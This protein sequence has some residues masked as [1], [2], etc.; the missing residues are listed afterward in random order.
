MK[1]MHRRIHI[2]IFL[3][4]VIVALAL[5][6]CRSQKYE[7]LLDTP[8]CWHDICPGVSTKGEAVAQLETLEFVGDVWYDDFY[9]ENRWNFPGAVG[10]GS[11]TYDEE[12]I[13]ESII[14]G[15]SWPKPKLDVNELLGPPPQAIA[16]IGCD[17]GDLATPLVIVL[18]YPDTYLTTFLEPRPYHGEPGE[19]QKIMVPSPPRVSTVSYHSSASYNDLLEEY[20]DRIDTID[21]LPADVKDGV[22]KLYLEK[23]C[24]WQ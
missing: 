2:R 7:A 14:V 20:V 21:T 12:Q 18:F 17:Y 3:A 13:V 5:S 24:S 19:T 16:F 23:G 22:T 6:S 11:I 1:V 8:P 9:H 4:V 15:F 10:G